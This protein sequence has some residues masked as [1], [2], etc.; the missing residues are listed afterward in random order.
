MPEAMTSPRHLVH[1]AHLAIRWGDMDALGHVNNTVYFR[2]M[3]QARLE[4]L[5]AQVGDQGYAGGS[6]PV[7]ANAICNFLRPLVYPADIEVRMSLGVPG[8][9]SVTSYYDIVAGGITF[10]HGEAR[11]VWIDLA[12]GRPT[13]LPEAVRA[14]LRALASP[15]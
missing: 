1:T 15:T 12:T 4:W 10:A 13:P 5:F 9:T 3:E 6:G 2:Y 8:T 14:P 11:I 7:I